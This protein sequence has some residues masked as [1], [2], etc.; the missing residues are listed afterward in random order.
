MK[1][2]CVNQKGVITEGILKGKEG[3]VVGFD[4]VEDRATIKL[5]EITFVEISSDYIHQEN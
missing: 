4:S 1:P 3:L 2:L 5:D